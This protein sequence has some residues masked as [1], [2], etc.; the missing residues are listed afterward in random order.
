MTLD[1]PVHGSARGSVRRSVRRSAPLS[2]ATLLLAAGLAPI[3][4]ST[5]VSAQDDEATVEVPTASERLGLTRGRH[6][7]SLFAGAQTGGL[8]LTEDIDTP[9]VDDAFQLRVDFESSSTFGVRYGY[10]FH[11]RWGFEV[12]YSR[13]DSELADDK[14]L[15]DELARIVFDPDPLGQDQTVLEALQTQL[16]PDEL[17]A[18]LARWEERDGPFDIQA[19]FL[20]LGFVFALNPRDRWVAEVNAGLGWAW[21][22]LDQ[23]AVIFETPLT[24]QV[25]PAQLVNTLVEEDPTNGEDCP[26]RDEPCR[27]VEDGSGLSWHLGAGLSFAFTDSVHLR[28]NARARWVEH[29]TDP[30]DS[31]MIPEATAGVSFLFG[32]Q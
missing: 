29:L 12:S 32:G 31:F 28:L 5:P 2:A 30:G 19:S 21:G 22:E 10:Q 8:A 1:A 23:G 7:I 24:T 6:R 9:P 17:D 11:E 20:D 3:L 27:R 25:S 14:T 18:L 16:S 13:A 26:F 15:K 4:C